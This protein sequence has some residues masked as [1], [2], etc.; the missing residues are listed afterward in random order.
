MSHLSVF[1]WQTTIAP[2]KM[3]MSLPNVLMLPKG[4]EIS[5]PASALLA[6]HSPNLLLNQPW[7]SSNAPPEKLTCFSLLHWFLQGWWVLSV[8]REI[9]QASERENREQGEY[10]ERSREENP[11]HGT[12]TCITS[13]T[14][15]AGCCASAAEPHTFCEQRLWDCRSCWKCSSLYVCAHR[16]SPGKLNLTV[17]IVW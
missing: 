6:P 8:R 2:I 16:T 15:Q 13:A 5:P 17:S 7:H 4:R 12:Q 9:K 3:Q 11:R 14:Q 1:K 10:T